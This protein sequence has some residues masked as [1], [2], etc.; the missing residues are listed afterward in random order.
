MP[1]DL[2]VY[3]FVVI[4]F[5]AI[6]VRFL[7]RDA[8]GTPRLPEIIDQ[9]VGM[10][11]LR[12]VL[13]RPKEPVED[14]PETFEIIPT[15]EEVAYRIGVAG[16]GR[17]V[18]RLRPTAVDGVAESPLDSGRSPSRVAPDGVDLIRSRSRRNA[19]LALQ[20]RLAAVLV[21]LLAGGVVVVV[22][23]APAADEGPV[24]ST[25]G[26]PSVTTE[27]FETEDLVD[28]TAMPT[29]PA[30]SGQTR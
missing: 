20:R 3:A 25:S 10:W 21:M 30:T 29:A 5:V 27:P 26:T 19:G 18:R 4:G 13:R 2:L 6:V 12:G 15:P 14:V 16:A 22:A 9:S 1:I 17:P 24:L 11:A 28:E 8:R 7:P 23:T